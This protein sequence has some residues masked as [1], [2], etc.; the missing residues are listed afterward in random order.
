MKTIELKGKTVEELID[1]FKYEN[2][3]SDGEFS[4]EVIQE[5]KKGLLGFI[6]TKNAIVKFTLDSLND[7]IKDYLREF[8]LLTQTTMD[9]VEIK[10]DKRYIYVEIS[11][12][13]DAGFLIGKD[14][15]FLSHLQYLL[16]ITFSSKDPMNRAIILDVESYK[17]RQKQNVIKKTKQLVQQAIKSNRSVTLEPMSSA[18]RRVV[19]QTLHN[20]TEITTLTIGDGPHKRIVIKPKGDTSPPPRRPYQP[21]RGREA[22]PDNSQE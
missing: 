3:L 4:F 9:S 14:G 19:H 7:D 12:V 16:N 5:P 2:N 13:S 17:R 21:R 15:A 1:L 6:G 18:H 20:M 8:G 10:R 22:R 11:D